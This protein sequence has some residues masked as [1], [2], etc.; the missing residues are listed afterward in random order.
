MSPNPATVAECLR[1]GAGFSQADRNWIV[2][3]FATLD[4]R[5]ASFHAD[6]TE[7]ELSVKDREAKGQKVT[8]ECWIAGRQKIVT[9]STEEDLHAALNDAR[10]DLRRKLNDAKTRQEPRN[11]KHLRVAP[12]PGPV[13]PGDEPADELA[14]AGTT[15]ER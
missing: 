10:D 13:T 5:L 9:T 14:G 3:Q 11:N 4:A 6:A 2:T 8:L 1:L 15:D 7:L 12:P